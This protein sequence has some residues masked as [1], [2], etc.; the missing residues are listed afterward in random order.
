MVVICVRLFYFVEALNSLQENKQT[1][2]KIFFL[3]C[4]YNHYNTL[5]TIQNKQTKVNI[6]NCIQQGSLNNV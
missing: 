6:L 4:Y 5:I 1:N 2:K 3:K